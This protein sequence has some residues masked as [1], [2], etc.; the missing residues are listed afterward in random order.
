[1]KTY[2]VNLPVMIQVCPIEGGDRWIDINSIVKI[3]EWPR[4]DHQCLYMGMS[5]E[6]FAQLMKDEHGDNKVQPSTLLTTCDIHLDDGDVITVVGVLEDILE[7]VERGALERGVPS[8][9][10]KLRVA[11]ATNHLLFDPRYDWWASDR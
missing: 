10:S 3:G 5:A 9:L 6:R 4:D 2:P 8:P 1:M 7:E 11:I